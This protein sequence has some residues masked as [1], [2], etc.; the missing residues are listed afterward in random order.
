MFAVSFDRH[1][2]AHSWA[3]DAVWRGPLLAREASAGYDAGKPQE[4]IGAD[5]DQAVDG[6]EA[7]GVH[8][9]GPADDAMCPA[10]GPT[11]DPLTDGGD[12]GEGSAQDAGEGGG[13]PVSRGGRVMAGAVAS[14][15]GTPG[16]R[17]AA[18]LT[19][20]DA[21]LAEVRAAVAEVDGEHVA[22]VG[23]G[24]VA[25]QRHRTS[26]DGVLLGLAGAF[27]ARGGPVRDGAATLGAWLRSRT[28]LDHGETASLVTTARRWQMLP[29]FAERLAAGDVSVRHVAGVCAKLTTPGRVEAIVGEQERLAEVAMTTSQRHLRAELGRVCEQVD[30]DGSTPAG[31]PGGAEGGEPAADEPVDRPWG[32]PDR[33]LW[34]HR[35]FQGLGDVRATLD[36]YVAELFDTALAAYDEPDPPGTPE[37]LRRTPAQRRHDA[38]ARILAAALAH[39]DAGTVQ[40]AK[41]RVLIVI[42]L[43]RLF[44]ITPDHPYASLTLRQLAERL[45]LDLSALPEAE[46]DTEIRDL[47]GWGP[48]AQP[49]DSA[50]TPT[51]EAGDVDAGVVGAA[52]AAGPDAAAGAPAAGGP[53]TGPGDGPTAA[54]APADGPRG[55]DA[56]DAADAA[57][58]RDPFTT[59]SEL[60]RADGGGGTADA[61][62][63]PPAP[64]G[65]AED[66]SS[67]PGSGSRGDPPGGDPPGGDPPDPDARTNGQPLSGLDRL[68]RFGSGFPIPTPKVRRLLEDATA[69][70]VLTLGPWRPVAVGRVHR[71]LPPWL[72][73]V[74][75]AM[76]QHCRG[77]DCDRHAAWTQASHETAWVDGGLTDVN[78]TLPLCTFH[79][80][81]RDEG[82]WTA[83]LDQTTGIVTWTDP[84][85]RTFLAHPPTH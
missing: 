49:Q 51:D 11:A 24:L 8:A 21:A 1:G 83:E 54:P 81:L 36:P 58:D 46:L 5:G 73:G 2:D 14:L 39:P 29:M 45:G 43:L 48:A 82:G 79:H 61:G 34:P 76:H 66:C 22:V 53:T 10:E 65:A 64:P 26:L 23:D 75:H 37:A 18:A 71:T 33:G 6:L 68:P 56:A 84:H 30:P 41:P 63:V 20:L 35:L 13:E 12:S 70:A 25:V 19:G 42:D 77:P 57:T 44:G 28:N 31:D 72:R 50:E 62:P 3:V 7:P 52:E 74:L 17:L 78:E 67:G 16:S 38:F 80:K 27:D 85:G 69:M 9:D 15:A 40:G 60:D 4:T 55:R 59:T 47:A 32:D